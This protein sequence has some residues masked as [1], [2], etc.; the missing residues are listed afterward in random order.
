[1][2]SPLSFFEQTPTG[3]YGHPLLFQGIVKF[4]P[5]FRILNIFSKDIYSIDQVL[6]RVSA[7][8]LF[9]YHGQPLRNGLQTIQG[10]FRTLA[11]CI[12]II[13][14]IGIVFPVFLLVVPPLAWFYSRVMTYVQQISRIDT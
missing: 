10:M 1:M 4:K 14:V 7:P 5:S 8:R 6:P 9:D 2:H 3:R 12:G 11:S 13:V